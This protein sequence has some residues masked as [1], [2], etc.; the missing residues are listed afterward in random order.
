MICT[1]V[2]PT[3]TTT[4]PLL[5]LV[6]KEIVPKEDTCCHANHC[7]GLAS[8]PSQH[9]R[10]PGAEQS[11][12]FRPCLHHTAADHPTTDHKAYVRSLKERRE[13]TAKAGKRSEPEET[14]REEEGMDMDSGIGDMDSGIE[15]TLSKFANDTK[16]CGVVDTLEGRD[17]IQRDLDRLGRWARVNH[18]KFNKAKCKVLHVGWRNPKHNYRLGEE[19]IERSPEEKDLVLIDEKLNMS[20]QCALAAQKANRV[21]GCL[22]RGVTSRSREVILP[23]YS[24]L[25][26]PH[27]EYCIQLWGPQYKKDT[28]LLERRATK[29]TGGLEHL[30]YEDGLRELG[31][32]S[33]EKRRLRANLLAAFWYLKGPTGKLLNGRYI[34]LIL[35]VQLAYLVQAVRAAG[36]CDAVFRGFS[37]CL[38]RLGDNMANYPQDLDD[39]RN[40]QTICAYWDDFHACTL[41]A[42]TDCQEGATDLWEKLRRESKNL[43]FQGSLFELC[44]GGSGAAPSLLLPAL[45]LLLAALWAALVTWLPF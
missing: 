30:S 37:D 12:W 23:L 6:Y 35:A 39:K 4:K 42:L 44:G 29:L 40:L 21:L 41:T 14:E 38:L 1:G 32:F 34:S 31:L 27:L 18:M 2:C 45:P 11:H 15:C 3:T 8:I 7:L 17:A 28:E 26:R 20:R 13:E 19:W 10:A 22:K 24:A 9:P 43:D 5:L 16:L 25:V 33:L 36:R